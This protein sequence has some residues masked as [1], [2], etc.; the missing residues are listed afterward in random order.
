MTLIAL[1]IVI[2][3]ISILVTMTSVVTGGPG[4]VVMLITVVWGMEERGVTLLL[5][6]TE[7][8][9]GTTCEVASTDIAVVLNINEATEEFCPLV[10]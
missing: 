1:V 4:A 3:V 5:V 10:G 6:I 8:R 9:D 2:V 7:V